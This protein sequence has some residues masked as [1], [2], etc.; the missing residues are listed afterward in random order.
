MTH[1][2]PAEDCTAMCADHM[3]MCRPHW[4]MVP[5]PQRGAVWDAYQNGAGIGTAEL[6]KAQADAI[7]AVNARIA[8]K[9]KKGQP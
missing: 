5:R 9:P 8:Q 3:L 2:C 4:Y 6:T 1:R 7:L